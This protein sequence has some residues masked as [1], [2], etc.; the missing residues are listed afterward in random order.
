MPYKDDWM[1]LVGNRMTL[2]GDWMPLT[3]EWMKGGWAEMP[4]GGG[5]HAFPT[6]NKPCSKCFPNFAFK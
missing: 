1:P 6:F 2:V 4:D 3:E 5:K